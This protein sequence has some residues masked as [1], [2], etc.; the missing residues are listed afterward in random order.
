MHV[1]ST[2][3]GCSEVVD[4]AC[5]P[6]CDQ[7]TPGVG[8]LEGDLLIHHRLAVPLISFRRYCATSIFDVLTIKVFW[9]S[10]GLLTAV[11]SVSAQQDV[12][13]LEPVATV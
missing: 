2:F 9:D 4:F 3:P 11:H 1:L 13:L 6:G 10:Y 12:R 5:I 7:V 8:E